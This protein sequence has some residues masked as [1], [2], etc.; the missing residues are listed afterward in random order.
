[1]ERQASGQAPAALQSGTKPQKCRVGDKIHSNL[2]Q[3][4]RLPRETE[5]RPG[6]IPPGSLIPWKPCTHSPEP[7]RS[8]RS[9]QARAGDS[10]APW[11]CNSRSWG[12]AALLHP[13]IWGRGGDTA[14]TGT[15]LSLSPPSPC[16]AWPQTTFTLRDTKR[17]AQFRAA[18]GSTYGDNAS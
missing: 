16:N 6:A 14:K 17:V 3:H 4:R 13:V 10:T 8:S 9:V 1:V 5:A 2:S 12:V 11:H 15:R 18:F 7:S